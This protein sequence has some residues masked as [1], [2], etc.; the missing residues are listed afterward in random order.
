MI[1]EAEMEAKA[2]IDKAMSDS[3]NAVATARRDSVNK[4]QEAEA[5]FRK[6][7]EAAV[8]KEMKALEAER[9]KL[10]SLGRDKAG[11]LDKAAEARIEK[12]KDF[13]KKEFERTIDATS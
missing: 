1:K 6:E 2:I 5:Q 8:A 7:F 11:Q 10:L 13:L 4:I 9:D 12:V 3:K